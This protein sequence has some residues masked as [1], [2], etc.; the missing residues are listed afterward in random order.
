MNSI[1]IGSD[2]IPKW[3]RLSQPIWWP[4]ANAHLVADR[5]L[6]CG[7]REHMVTGS[8]PAGLVIDNANVV[9]EDDVPTAEFS[10]RPS[11]VRADLRLERRLQKEK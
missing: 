7:Q 11:H 9:G 8:V 4:Q 6:P 3:E 10:S 5:H 1:E 2:G